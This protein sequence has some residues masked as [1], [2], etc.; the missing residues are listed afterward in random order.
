M[1]D[2]TGTEG[3]LFNGAELM[4][5]GLGNGSFQIIGPN[6]ELRVMLHY[7]GIVID[8]RGMWSICPLKRCR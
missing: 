3:R 2:L 5:R 4:K 6:E 1:P 7:H 8:S